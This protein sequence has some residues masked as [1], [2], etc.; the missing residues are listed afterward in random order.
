MRTHGHSP[1]SLSR[2]F[3][4]PVLV[5]A[6]PSVTQSYLD[7]HYSTPAPSCAR[8][9]WT[10][11]KPSWD[12]LRQDGCMSDGVQSATTTLISTLLIFEGS[13]TSTTRVFSSPP[14]IM[15]MRGVSA[16][17]NDWCTST[18]AFPTFISKWSISISSYIPIWS[19]RQMKVCLPSPNLS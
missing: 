19:K 15:R 11:A 5:L 13:S 4:N 14:Q 1:F 7:F 10:K 18:L 16:G 3:L 6:Q 9:L 8:G 17:P 2:S 12:G